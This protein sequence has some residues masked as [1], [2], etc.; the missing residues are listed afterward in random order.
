MKELVTVSQAAIFLDGEKYCRYTWAPEKYMPKIAKKS[1]MVRLINQ[2]FLN[3]NSEMMLSRKTPIKHNCCN[4]HNGQGVKFNVSARHI[5]INSTKAHMT[6]FVKK[7]LSKNFF[8]N[9]ITL[10]GYIA[11][12]FNSL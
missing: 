10:I 12:T 9:L 6:I 7:G 8:I 1:I 2:Y 4:M 11:Q 3:L 5:I